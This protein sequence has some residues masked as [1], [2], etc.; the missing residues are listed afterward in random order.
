MRRLK[1]HLC[2]FLIIVFMCLIC[3]CATEEMTELEEADVSEGSGSEEKEQ[4]AQ[5]NTKEKIEEIYVYV[6]GAVNAPGVYRLPAGS[7][8]YEAIEAAGGM[9]ESAAA[10][11][12]NQAERLSDGQQVYM[13]GRAETAGPTAGSAA[14]GAGM[15]EDGKVNL[16]S[17]G[18]EE[19]MTL[20]GIGE[21]KA[22]SIIRYRE[23]HGRFQSVEELKQI[24]G[25]KEGLFN[26]IKDKVRI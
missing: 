16:N 21:V 5:E 10:E 6:C 11:A 13:P 1:Q 9:N 14:G 20:S 25:I 12:L 7:R 19:L 23:E 2:G 15:Q 24:E 26:R 8:V 22:E 4:E 17:A 18:K 3:G